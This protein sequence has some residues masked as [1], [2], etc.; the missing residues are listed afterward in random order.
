MSAE[1][2]CCP[3]TTAGTFHVIIFTP[4]IFPFAHMADFRNSSHFPQ[5]YFIKKTTGNRALI[6]SLMSSPPLTTKAVLV[7]ISREMSFS[8]F[9]HKELWRIPS[10][11]TIVLGNRKKVISIVIL[12]LEII[13]LMISVG[14]NAFTLIR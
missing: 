9:N 14:G 4:C 5:L 10:L 2:Q 3:Q 7:H 11:L 12:L 6:T 8:V 13:S 1:D